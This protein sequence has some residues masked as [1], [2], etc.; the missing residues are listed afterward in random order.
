MIRVHPLLL[1]LAQLLRNRL[2]PPLALRVLPR[3]LI[4]RRHL[5]LHSKRWNCLF[6]FTPA[7]TCTWG[8]CS[9]IVGGVW[10][11]EATEMCAAA[12]VECAGRRLYGRS[13][14]VVGLQARLVAAEL[15]LALD[16]EPA[17]V[18]A[19]VAPDGLEA[20]PAPVAAAAEPSRGHTVAAAAA[21][22]VEHV[23]L[24]ELSTTPTDYVALAVVAC[25]GL[26]LGLVGLAHHH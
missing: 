20:A 2:I 10:V 3:R 22:V 14:Q 18:H 5:R 23:E 17:L 24:A 26:G 6:L 13:S 12:K 9:T 25:S 16:A 8:C 11:A 15:E 19:P 21:V 1:P 7:T 4:R